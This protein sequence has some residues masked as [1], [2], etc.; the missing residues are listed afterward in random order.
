MESFVGVAIAW[1]ILAFIGFLMWNY[2]GLR[3]QVS[4]G[5]LT[6]VY[7]MFNKKSFSIDDL[8]YCKRTKANLG[9]YFGIGIRYGTDGSVAYTTSFG[10]AI[11]VAP[12]E[13]KIFVFSS[14]QP[15]QVCEAINNFK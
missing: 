2:R 3:I 10:D 14:K 6:V 13:G 11:E 1:G 15:D 5:R 8:T 7:G 9:R 12:K 4:G